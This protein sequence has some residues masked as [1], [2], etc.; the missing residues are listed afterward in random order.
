MIKKRHFKTSEESVVKKLKRASI[1]LL[2][3][4]LK[5]DSFN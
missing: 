2:A 1:V 4:N 3:T 5:Q